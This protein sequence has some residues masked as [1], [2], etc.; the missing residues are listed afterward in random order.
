MI[1]RR[2]W[3]TGSAGALMLGAMPIGRG[4]D[5]ADAGGAA[6]DEVLFALSGKKPLIKRSFRPPNFETP[7]ADLRRPFTANDAFFVRYHLAGIPEIEP[8]T[9]RRRVGGASVSR[10]MELTLGDLQSGFERIDL[11]AVNQ[12]AGNRRAF[13]APRVPGVQWGNGAMGH[14][15]WSGVRLRDVLRK[16]G[17][18]SDALEVVFDGAD[19][20]VL[21]QTPDFQKSL[22]MDRALDENT[23]IAFAMNARPLPHFNGAPARLIVPGWTGTYW[24]KHLTDIRVQPQPFEGFWMKAAYRIPTGAFPGARF[25]SQETPETTAITQIL[26]N[27]LVTNPAPHTRL[28]R[29]RPAE[30]SGWAW[31]GGTGISAVEVSTDAGVS[32]RPTTLE[33]DLGRFAWRGFR[34][35][36][37]TSRSGLLALAVRATSRGGE[38]QPE[39]LTVNAA[40]YHDNRISSLVLE[41]A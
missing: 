27:S 29:H 37:D 34:L 28:V 20:A 16:C 26:V 23:L 13:F 15:L 3:L 38:R 4:D 40:G 8:R 18:R 36:L 9:W 7:L 22:P 11:P 41:V 2:R 5:V 39:K 30:L 6:A 25:V 35:A 17:L 14:A 33:K 24:V 31:D 19:A 32:W 12:C 10:P 21:P 1:T